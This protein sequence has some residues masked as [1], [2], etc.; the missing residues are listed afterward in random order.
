MIGAFNSKE[1]Q[2]KV[3]GKHPSSDAP[4][5]ELKSDK[6][7][8]RVR[9]RSRSK[10]KSGRKMVKCYYYHE[11]HIKRNYTKKRK[12]FL[13]RNNTN[14]GASICEFRYDSSDALIVTKKSESEVWI[15]DSGCSYHMTPNKLVLELSENKW[16]QST[17]RK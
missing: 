8:P 12:D 6:R 16:R 1:L 5:I 10:S 15:M 2:Y 3:K 11:G 14:G 17:A 13:D 9:G 4:T 7:E